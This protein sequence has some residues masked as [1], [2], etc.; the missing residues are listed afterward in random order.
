MKE[1]LETKEYSFLRDPPLGDNIIL[2][3]LGGSHAYG[4]NIEGS[5]IDIR[6]VATNSAREILTGKG[7]EQVENHV[8]DTVVYS[9][10]K[11]V[12]LLA[13]CNPNCIEIL[14][15][16]PWQYLRITDVGQQLIDNADMFLSKKAAKS[17][18][19]YANSQLW[20]LEQKI[21]RGAK[22]SDRE[23]HILNS[24]EGA[25]YSFPEK[26]FEYPEDSIRLYIDDAVGEGMDTEIFMDINLR[27]Y[28]L[29]DYKAM[30]AEMNNIAKS[31]SK[32]GQRNS[33]AI[34]AGKLAKHQMHLIRLLRMSLDLLNEGRIITYRRDDHDLL[35][36][37]R[38]GDFLSEDGLIYAEFY[39]MVRELEEKLVEAQRTTKLPDK[40]DY[41]R[42]DDFVERVNKEIVKN[43]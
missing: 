41:K 22:Q 27:H 12:S 16:E 20:R 17:F 28:P 38:N 6:G 18:G 35:M 34:E 29:R 9:L 43:G 10:K 32:L 39:D 24:I 1:I 11:M 8:T 2:L 5:D 37:I 30:W 21:I 25:S 15:L 31:Y 42:I 3:G 4:T 26:Y 36:S 19:G 33:K 7:F 14:G 23:Q 13:N 40:P